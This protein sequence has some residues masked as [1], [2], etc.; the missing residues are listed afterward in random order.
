MKK[1]TKIVIIISLILI[2][3]VGIFSLI[4]L[5]KKHDNNNEKLF[6]SNMVNN[7]EKE[8]TYLFENKV[9]L[10]NDADESKVILFLGDI[11]R[12]GFSIDD[13]VNF[14]DKEQ[15][16]LAKSFAERSVKN[17]KV[18]IKVYYSCGDKSNYDVEEYFS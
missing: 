7:M 16:D 9:N 14:K 17:G 6:Y 5:V 13:Y 18:E 8:Y 15:C 4:Y 3:I 12:F 10:P 1:S 2:L 11:K